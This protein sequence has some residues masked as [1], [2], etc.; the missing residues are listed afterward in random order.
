MKNNGELFA[1]IRELKTRGHSFRDIGRI[2]EIPFQRAHRLY[3]RGP[4]SVSQETVVDVGTPAE[5][6]ARHGLDP[7]LW[8]C[9]KFKTWEAQKKGGQTIELCSSEFHK[10]DPAIRALLDVEWKP[11]PRKPWETEPVNQFALVVPD[12]Q[13][14][15]ARDLDE[16]L[17]P[18]HDRRALDL[19]VQVAQR[20]GPKLAFI[21]FLGDMLDCAENTRKFS[22]PASAQRTFWPALL[23]W[24]W[25]LER[26]RTAAPHADCYW[27]EGNHEL[28]LRRVLTDAAPE[29]C[30]LP[31]VDD[32]N[33]P[34]LLSIERLCGLEAI[35]VSYLSPY[36]T[37]A[38][39]LFH[40]WGVRF[41]HGR[42]VG[43]KGG[44]SV[45]KNLNDALV[46]NVF[47]HV[48]RLE[49]AYATRPDRA[50]NRREMFAA[51]FGCLCHTDGRVPSNQPHHDWQQGLGIL[52][53]ASDGWVEPTPVR[54]RPGGRA[55]VLGSEMRGVDYVGQLRAETQYPF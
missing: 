19:C 3:H 45:S 37:K 26:F 22:R 29:V 46:S 41:H 11:K 12:S 6:L 14:G 2:L 38:G 39:E 13:I 31:P 47:G 7:S 20:L 32:R 51:T 15:Y 9:S 5:V 17:T 8:R 21:V 53:K 4:G 34:A 52:A 40:P 27:L 16:N 50:G 35:D 44:Q 25:L 36:A 1:K 54:I 49:L 33:G 18:Y 48:H 43:G 30:E 28:R 10:I 24:R 42:K 55:V 23:E